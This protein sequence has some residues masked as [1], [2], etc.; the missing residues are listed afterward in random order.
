MIDWA[1][2]GSKPRDIASLVL[3]A[4]AALA[5]LAVVYYFLI[6]RPMQ[7]EDRRVAY[8][9]CLRAADTRHEQRGRTLEE[10]LERDRRQCLA[11]ARSDLQSDA[12]LG[13]E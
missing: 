6:H 7:S 3:K 5:C 13:L 9:S 12:D 11:E 1:P 8:Q 2:P 4:S 10:W